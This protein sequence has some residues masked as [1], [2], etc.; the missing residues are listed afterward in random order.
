MKYIRG[1]TLLELIIVIA[2][3][4]FLASIALSV[5]DDTRAKGRDAHRASQLQEI[6]KAAELYYADHGVYPDDG[7][8]DGNIISLSNVTELLIEQGGYLSVMPED[9]KWGGDSADGYL[10]CSSDDGDSFTILMQTEY[11]G[12][13]YCFASRGPD[14]PDPG[15]CTDFSD[16]D[17]LVTSECTNRF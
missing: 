10:Y 14:N 7:V 17:T 4:G 6:L 1:F 16:S 8:N 2:I 11:V 12:K 13:N 9:P 5:L 15:Y 3:I